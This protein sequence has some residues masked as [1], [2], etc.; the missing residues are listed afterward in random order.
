MKF[1]H[2]V[3]NFFND[4]EFKI[5]L[6]DISRDE[7]FSH[8]NLSGASTAFEVFHDRISTLL[9]EHA[10]IYKLNKKKYLLRLKHGSWLMK[11]M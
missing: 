1:I 7:I 8:N 2:V 9:S 11:V 4:V 5:D 3:T 10:P 6:T